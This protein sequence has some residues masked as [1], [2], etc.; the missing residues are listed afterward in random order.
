MLNINL[1]N[2]DSCAAITIA[3]ALIL[4]THDG[5]GDFLGFEHHYDLHLPLAVDW[6]SVLLM[7]LGFWILCKFA[8]RTLF[9]PSAR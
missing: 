4:Y 7:I 8:N 9:G 3:Y 5:I 6:A 2:L 1:N